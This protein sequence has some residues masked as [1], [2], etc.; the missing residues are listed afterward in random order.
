MPVYS[1][2]VSL[3]IKK[4]PNVLTPIPYEKK[5][6]QTWI[7]I[8]SPTTPK[9]ANGQL[10]A[11]SNDFQSSAVDLHEIG[12]IKSKPSTS[13]RFSDENVEI[14]MLDDT[15]WS[16]D[17]TDCEHHSSRKIL[18]NKHQIASM[19]LSGLSGAQA[20]QQCEVLIS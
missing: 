16:S 7:P 15:A 12:P 8:A 14:H 19:K 18:R 20:L 4:F 13:V 3:R 6:N 17:N 5:P 9:R 11:P 2:P 10:D 1:K